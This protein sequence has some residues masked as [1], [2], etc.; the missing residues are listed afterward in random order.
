MNL[1]R[2]QRKLG[3]TSKST[4]TNA[5]L[6]KRKKEVWNLS[7]MHRLHVQNQG[8]C[9]GEKC[10]V[11]VNITALELNESR[12]IWNYVSTGTFVSIPAI[13]NKTDE[14]LKTEGCVLKFWHWPE[15]ESG[16]EGSSEN[17]IV[18]RNVMERVQ[19]III[20]GSDF[21]AINASQSE[22]VQFCK[23]DVCQPDLKL[24][25]R[26]IAIADLDG[27][28]S[29]ELISYQSSYD[30]ENPNVLTSKVQVVKLDAVLETK[31]LD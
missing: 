7:P 30:V 20:N 31:E 8:I 4:L 15:S 11:T 28:R 18:K 13:L 29:S 16:K 23:K 2:V 22:V 5:M 27:D 1:S 3:L 25:T 17:D 9:P 24:Q 26:S 10:Q 19:M 12:V 6:S 21:H 14:P